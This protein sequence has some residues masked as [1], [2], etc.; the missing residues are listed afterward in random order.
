MVYLLLP[1]GSIGTFVYY[2][3]CSFVP[4]KGRAVVF[5]EKCF[6][7]YG[8]S[9]GFVDADERA[10]AAIKILLLAEKTIQK[11]QTEL[12]DT[13]IQCP[14]PPSHGVYFDKALWKRTAR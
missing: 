5:E 7:L 9:H 6:S 14:A 4:Q 2:I 12:P 10:V 8:S 13:Q 3:V 1:V 11:L